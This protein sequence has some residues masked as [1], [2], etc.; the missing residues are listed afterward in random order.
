MGKRGR[1]SLTVKWPRSGPG[2]K[3]ITYFLLVLR[4]RMIAAVTPLPLYAFM[5]YTARTLSSIYFAEVLR[6]QKV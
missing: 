1:F 2:T 6:I 3:L 5:V 4:L